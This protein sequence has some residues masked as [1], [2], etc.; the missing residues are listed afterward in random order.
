M[1]T[2]MLLWALAGGPH[3]PQADTPPRLGF[4]VASIKPSK[5]GGFDG[6]IK[7]MPSGQGYIA[8][9]IPAKL[10]IM[11]MYHLNDRQVSG[12]PGW[13]AATC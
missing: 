10:M 8:T 12:G 3:P 1:L 5:P 13:L 2:A 11:L 6:G 9:N 4:E 7:P